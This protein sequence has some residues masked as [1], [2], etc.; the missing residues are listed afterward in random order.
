MGDVYIHHLTLIFKILRVYISGLGM[1]FQKER[2]I[3][4]PRLDVQFQKARIIALF[5]KIKKKKKQL[6]EMSFEKK[7][8]S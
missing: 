8:L 4:V 1:Q 2:I 7:I 6:H 5:F 3:Y